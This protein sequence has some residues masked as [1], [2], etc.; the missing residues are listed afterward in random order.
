[1]AIRRLKTGRYQ[2]DI[3]DL[4]RGLARVKRTFRTRREAQEWEAA[5]RTEAHDRLLG[6]RPRTLFGQAL[7]R[8]LDE[9]SPAKRSHQDDLD[10]LTALRWP[11]PDGRGGWSTLEHAPLD[12]GPTG[13]VAGLAAWTA[14]Q[15][16]I[17]A[18]VHL[19]GH[20][21]HQR[22]TPEG[23]AWYCQPA[24]GADARPRPRVL[25]T[26]PGLLAGIAAQKGRG[27]YSTGT[28][29]VRQALVRRVLSLAF[30][31]W[32]LTE[33]D[34]AA[35]VETDR[36]AGSRT[37]HLTPDQLTR[38]VIALPPHLDDAALGAAWIGW[39]RANLLGRYSPRRGRTI[40]GLTWDRVVF[41]IEQDGRLIQ[42]GYCWYEGEAAKN[43]TAHET[44]L[45]HRVEALLAAR[46]AVRNGPLVFHDGTGRPWGDFRKAWA[47]ACRTAG[48]PAGLRWH[49]L[50]H[51]W[52]SELALSG[53]TDRQIQELGGWRNSAMVQR[54][55]HLR[56]EHLLEVLN[57]I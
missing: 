48:L 46:W 38:L 22:R 54:Y 40:E 34:L 18:R 8:Y 30:R 13:I 35:L 5:V 25:V 51:T 31:H 33:T 36:P 55:A 39:R 14:D 53:A 50:R 32:R 41:S 29:R 1:M 49:D 3:Q 23:P 57:R 37:T 17:L 56:R 28:L 44:P 4:K 42:P 11:Y 21:Y 43:R 16:G 7:S 26:D 45:S 9:Y 6:R 19:G 27:P 24:P 20:T 15:K 52:A 2:A 12:D 47:T 10:N